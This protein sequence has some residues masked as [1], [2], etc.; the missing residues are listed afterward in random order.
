[1]LLFSFQEWAEI[2][3]HGTEVGLVYNKRFVTLMSPR[4]FPT[5]SLSA[6]KTSVESRKEVLKSR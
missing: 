6:Y 5:K 4:D 3:L 2:G 1:M